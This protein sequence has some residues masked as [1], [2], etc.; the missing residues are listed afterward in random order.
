M[1]MTGKTEK[2][3]TGLTCDTR[4]TDKEVAQQVVEDQRVNGAEG[5]EGGALHVRS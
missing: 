5:L 2:M 3:P 1:Q 4:S